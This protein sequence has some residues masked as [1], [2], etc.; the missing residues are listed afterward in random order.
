VSLHVGRRVTFK[1]GRQPDT[2]TLVF[3]VWN[4]TIR[5][6]TLAVHG[7]TTPTVINPSTPKAKTA[8]N[9]TLVLDTVEELIDATV[10]SAR[11]SDTTLGLLAYNIWNATTGHYGTLTDGIHSAADNDNIVGTSYVPTTLSPSSLEVY[12]NQALNSLRRHMTND[13]DGTG[14]GSASSSYHVSGIADWGHVPLMTGVH[15]PEDTYIGLSECVRCYEYH[16]EETTVHNGFA[17]EVNT[18]NTTPPTIMSIEIEFLIV[19]ASSSPDPAVGEA[20]GV[21]LMLAWGAR[22]E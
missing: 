1:L 18:I 9:G 14:A 8:A 22:A 13:G 12:V 4:D 21:A 5:A 3:F 6:T 15:G 17:D 20:S 7:E 16:R 11:G 2:A 10:E 19:L